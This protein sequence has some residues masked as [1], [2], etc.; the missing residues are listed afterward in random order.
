M[1]MHTAAAES[2]IVAP[3]TIEIMKI[4]RTSAHI[5]RKW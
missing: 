1:A 4:S 2:P 3:K 5:S